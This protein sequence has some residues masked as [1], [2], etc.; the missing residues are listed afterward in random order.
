MVKHPCS[1]CE[2][3][4]RKNQK[5]LLCTTC[6]KWV[7]INCGHVLKKQYECIQNKFEN[8]ECP[9]CLFVHMPFRDEE[10]SDLDDG[11][12]ESIHVTVDP[13]EGDLGDQLDG[14]NNF[15]FP[16]DK[17][18]K[19]AHLNIRSL[20]NKVIDLQQLLIN[21]PYD[22]L[23]LS[24]TWLD[25]DIT[26]N[27]ITIP[28]YKF[29]RRDRGQ[30]GGGV[31]CYIKEK[32]TY[33]RRFDLE[34]NEL[35]LMWLEIK[36]SNASSLF[37]AV[38]Y[39]KPNEHNLYFEHLENT[40]ENVLSFS[41]NVILLGD[42][43]CNMLTENGLSKKVK[44]LCISM[45][46]QQLVKQPTRINPHSSTLIDL[47]ITLNVD[48]IVQ[49]GVQ[50]VGFSDH[51]LVYTVLK[52]TC[53]LLK[54]KVSKFRSFRFFDKDK[55]IKDILE[56][57][58][59]KLYSDDISVEEL[60]MEFKTKFVELSNIH[61]P[62]IS[63]RRKR[64]GAP[65]ITNEYILLARERDYFRKK[66]YQTKLQCH[67]DKFKGFRNKAN[68]MN[69]KLKRNFYQNEFLECG[70]DIKKNWK[71][72]KNLLPNKNGAMDVKLVIEG[73]IIT[74]AEEIASKLNVAF[75]EVSNRLNEG[76]PPSVR[77]INALDT[78]CQIDKE[79]KFKEI[80]VEFVRNELEN[81]NCKK[82][83]GVDGL[84]PKLLKLAV[85][86][87]AAPL[88]HIFN[89]SLITSD[90]PMD[91]KTARITPIHKGGAF[92]ISNFRPISILPI[93]SKILEKAVHKQLYDFLNNNKLLSKEQSGF[94]PLHSTATCV[95]HIVDFLLQNMDSGQLI[96]AVF[97]DLK[98]AFDVIPLHLILAKLS[99]Y[100]I[101][102]DEYKWFESYLLS[103][104]HCVSVQGCSSNYLTVQSGVPQG[105]ILGPLIF[106]LF[107]NDIC[108]LSFS[109]QSKI[110]LYADDTAIFN[111]DSDHSQ[112]QINLQ[113]DFDLIVKWLKYNGMY[114]H[115]DKTKVITF[116]PKRKL[117]NL[118]LS[119]KYN[120]SELENVSHLKYLGVILDSQLVWS[121]HIETIC[122]KI[123]RSIAC[124][125]R[126]K[127]LVPNKVLI[128][129]Y[130]AL[131]LPYIDYCCTAWGSCS[132]ANLLKIQ[133]LQNRYA[134]LVLNVDRFTSKCFLL[135]TLNWQSVEQR[136][137]YHY[138][139]IMYKALNSLTPVYIELLIERRTTHYVT[140][141][142]LRSPLTVPYPRTE[143]MKR[144][145]VYTG[146]SLFNK[147]PISIQYSSS[148]SI[149]KQKSRSAINML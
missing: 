147:L 97:L 10:S 99:F 19:I 57:D 73:N 104:K 5:A 27:M 117:H 53:R 54:P 128:N 3:P 48:N 124:I 138:C 122:L 43:N 87:I 52:G 132:K 145:F 65:W 134:R 26:D 110:S 94:R 90:I 28:G 7:H 51:A 107:I 136:I 14:T 130:Y 72:L 77:D 4:V 123:S 49:S 116:G 88:A 91:F 139:V 32:Y 114:I 118:V 30:L 131:I 89:R 79:F 109:S 142:T 133:K 141:Y 98:K 101:R 18:I 78:L 40:I 149:F 35:E 22:I 31:G 15:E 21:N 66:Y 33:I 71:I 8:W 62:F 59:S 111:K 64:H 74:D 58:W 55:F 46:M 17:G 75:N 68:N 140:R 12:N 29:E 82:A 45:Q 137:K 83:V 86:Y 60:W 105:S 61:A 148:L 125:R 6:L 44:E 112:I 13:H 96:G 100:G 25:E 1:C 34:P 126:I 11:N 106:C 95:T 121:K 47:I 120:D 56:V 36:K 24:E 143:Y 108:K 80:S 102:N 113:R 70:S 23:C 135:T 146:S 16:V 76:A 50:C 81:I 103:R 84:H 129:L 92:E 69:K 20:R 67:W 37:V 144:S 119:I 127:H 39:R 85:E 115:P 38:T 42:F 41:N 9:K 2:K 63:V 93:L